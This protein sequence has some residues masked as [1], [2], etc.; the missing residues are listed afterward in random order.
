MT[1]SWLTPTFGVAAALLS[2]SSFVPQVVKLLREKTSE[3]VSV[4]MYVLTM[5]AFACWCAYGLLLG[6]WPLMAANAISFCLASAILVL[7]LRYQAN[8]DA[9][10][11]GDAVNREPPARVGAVAGGGD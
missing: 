5:S 4:G 11:A 3:A 10:A 1:P 9:Q 8:D 2:I 6:S 7:K